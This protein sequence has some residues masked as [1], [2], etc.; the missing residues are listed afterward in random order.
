MILASRE[1]YYNLIQC[2]IGSAEGFE[3]SEPALE[4]VPR[5][6]DDNG[7][8]AIDSVA[9]DKN[10]ILKDVLSNATFTEP[11]D[12]EDDVLP[13]RE[14]AQPPKSSAEGKKKRGRKP[15]GHKFKKFLALP[16]V[17]AGLHL[18]DM[19][20]EYSTIMN[21]NVLFYSMRHM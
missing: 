19:A 11:E 16:N 21:V 13:L 20:R 2:E 8:N 18:A 5:R 12:F 10:E 4:E 14:R 17:H 3:V 1:A 6:D 9:E 15:K 7:N